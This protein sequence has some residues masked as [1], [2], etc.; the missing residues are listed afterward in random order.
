MESTRHK[1]VDWKTV[2]LKTRLVLGTPRTKDNIAPELWQDMAHSLWL[3]KRSY[4]QPKCCSVSCCYALAVGCEFWI[5]AA[6][7]GSC[8]HDN[9][10]ARRLQIK[11]MEMKMVYLWIS[12][13]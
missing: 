13:F 7:I 1:S 6:A 2:T 3:S 11:K 5:F 8:Y 10:M 12:M 9:V 4:R